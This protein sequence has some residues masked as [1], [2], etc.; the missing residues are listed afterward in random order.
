LGVRSPKQFGT[1]LIV[2]HRNEF[3]K[4]ILPRVPLCRLF[5]AIRSQGLR[6]GKASDG[7]EML[8]RA[9]VERL[10]LST[11]VDAVV[12]SESC[13]R[14]KPSAQFFEALLKALGVRSPRQAMMVGDSIVRDIQGAQ[15]AGIRIALVTVLSAE[16]PNDRVRPDLRLLTV[17]GLGAHIRLAG[18]T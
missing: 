14:A 5:A 13:G 15:A 3:W 4:R 2:C 18:V 16:E 17:Y 12:T 11:M 8:Q 9:T 6:I 7:D 10:G 1:Q